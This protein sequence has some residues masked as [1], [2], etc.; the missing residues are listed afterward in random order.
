MTRRDDRIRRRAI[1]HRI[2]LSV[3]LLVVAGTVL[4]VGAFALFTD[5]Q[6][7]SQSV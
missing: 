6:S 7:V 1:H 4:G 3:A 2:V 5:T